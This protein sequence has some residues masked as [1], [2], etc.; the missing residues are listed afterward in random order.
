[1]LH[2]AGAI[3]GDVDGVAGGRSLLSLWR[4]SSQPNFRVRFC[5]EDAGADDEEFVVAGGMVTAVDICNDD[6]RVVSVSM[7]L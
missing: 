7:S 6:E 1:M 2:V 5:F 3:A 4:K